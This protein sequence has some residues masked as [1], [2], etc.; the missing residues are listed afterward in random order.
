MSTMS[1]TPGDHPESAPQTPQRPV[2]PTPAEL[3][4][5]QGVPAR[6]ASHYAKG[7]AANMIRS[8][9]VILAITLALF[10]IGGRTNGR[11]Q[12]TVDVPGTAQFRADQA[13]HPFAYPKGLPKGW[14]ATSVRYD[15]SETGVMV[16][17]AGYSTPDE[18]FVSVQ[19]AI[20]PEGDW[21]E[22]QT[23]QGEPAGELT[24]EDGTEW[25]KLERAGKSQRSLVH[26]PEAAD[27]A[28][29]IVTGSGTWQ[30]LETVVN[31][32]VEAQPAAA[33]PTS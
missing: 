16:W 31:H 20:D 11:T 15:R 24:A 30:Q 26:D 4:A 29:T 18:E 8:M 3:A 33:S 10:F 1:S 2:E 7:T 14:A 27:E 22:V 23:E 9:A 13:G 32:L 28:T 17:N 25:T 5:Q 19:Q 6:G 21:L 12:D